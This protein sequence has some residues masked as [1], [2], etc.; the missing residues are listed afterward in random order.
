MNDFFENPN[1]E[2]NYS[3]ITKIC[4]FDIEV[5]EKKTSP[6]LNQE[7]N[8]FYINSGKGILK[9]NEKE[10][11]IKNNTFILISPWD[12]TE[13]TKVETDFQL[14]RITYNFSLINHIMKVLFNTN[15]QQQEILSAFQTNPVLYC[16]DS[17]AVEIKNIFTK[18]Q[19]EVGTVSFIENA[20]NQPLSSVF[21]IN[22]IVE[23]LIS[24]YRIHNN[25]SITNTKNQISDDNPSLI[26]RYIFTHLND[27]L[28]IRN[29]SK[30]FYMSE[31]SISKYIIDTTGRSFNNLV[32]EIRVVK[33]MNYLI[34]TDFT[35]EELASIMGYVDSAHISKVFASRMDN[36]ISDYR[37]TYQS[38]LRCCN[39]EDSK[40][41]YL[42]INFL[43]KNHCDDISVQT[44]AKNFSLT[45]T[46]LNNIVLIE[47]EKSFGDFINFLRI[48]T[49]SKLLVDTEESISDIAFEV[50]YNTVK[51]FTRNFVKIRNVN[52]GDFRKKTT[53]YSGSELLPF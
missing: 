26:F 40:K 4:K 29:L 52:P 5:I 37:K 48:G 51:T 38:S 35:L 13:I 3:D 7:S 12:C 16:S 36:K 20:P 45:P 27:K 47:T 44:V 39:M 23:L 14:Y 8:L 1:I 18:V 30:I 22:L 53:L 9:I 32:N 10:F 50:G 46:E 43:N 15:K 11:E 6:I 24:F 19:K 17:E 21:S 33:T 34:Y 31:S 41:G 42:I 2:N 49:A 25:S 28:T